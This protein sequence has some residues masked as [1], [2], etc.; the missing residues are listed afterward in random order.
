MA[1]LVCVKVLYH[2]NP[3][4]ANLA[5]IATTVA[6]ILANIAT[7]ISTVKSAKFAQGGKVTGPGY[8]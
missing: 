5:A 3:I 8:K 1:E 7:A 6:T 4:P 2:L